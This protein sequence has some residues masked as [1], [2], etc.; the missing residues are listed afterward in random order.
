MLESLVIRNLKLSTNGPTFDNCKCM[1]NVRAMFDFISSISQTYCCSCIPVSWD[2]AVE[3][4]GG[5]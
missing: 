2:G 1:H 5:A 3:H 4:T